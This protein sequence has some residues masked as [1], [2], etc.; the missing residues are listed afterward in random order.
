M[1]ILSRRRLRHRAEGAEG[2]VLLLWARMCLIFIFLKEDFESEAKG[3]LP[4]R[5]KPKENVFVC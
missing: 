3:A 2:G 1:R 5:R 4:A